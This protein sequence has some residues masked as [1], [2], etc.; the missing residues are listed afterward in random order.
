[1]TDVFSTIPEA[2]SALK[3]GKFIVVVD[4]YA[5]ENEGDLIIAAECMTPSKMSFLLQVTSGIVCISL[6]ESRLKELALPLMVKNNTALQRTAFTITV[7]AKENTTTGISAAERSATI[8]ALADETKGKNDFRRPGHI[9]PLQARKGGVLKRAGHTEAGLDLMQLAGLKPA[10]VLCE[11]VNEDRSMAKGEALHDF[12]KK[13]GLPIISIADLILYRREKESLITLISEAKLPTEYGT[14]NLKIYRSELDEIEHMV[15][16]KG[17]IEKDEKIL[18]RVHSECLTGDI[19]ASRRCDCGEQLHFSLDAI[20]K[21]KSGVLV[22]LRGQEGRGIGLG[23]KIRAYSL[24]E[25]GY[26]TVDANIQ[27][28]FPV[29]SREY[30]IGA[31][32]LADLGVKKVRLLTNNPAKYG[33]LKGFGIEVVERVPLTIE[34]NE[35]NHLYLLAKAKKLGHFIDI[36]EKVCRDLP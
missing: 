36:K 25:N 26:D 6:P 17:K 18:V 35:D 3:Q 34:P 19:F 27:L 8:V 10:A 9:F 15:L 7:D 13:Y 33:G 30:G 24:Q 4:D 21:E 22:Y 32:I 16:V 29:D 31:Q 20:A 14:F 5:R 23:H 28:G 2:L 12:A 1:M 11:I